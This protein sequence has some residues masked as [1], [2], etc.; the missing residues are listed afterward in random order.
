MCSIELLFRF[1][2]AIIL[3]C[4]LGFSSNAIHT[5]LGEEAEIKVKSFFKVAFVDCSLLLCVSDSFG[6][7]AWP[8]LIFRTLSWPG[9]LLVFF[10][11]ICLLTALSLS[12]LPFLKNNTERCKLNT[13]SEFEPCIL[14]CKMRKNWLYDRFSAFCGI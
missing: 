1:S 2:H 13:S 7:F 9:S 6:K 14:G 3:D 5:R 10:V 12:L 11:S 4:M 8:L